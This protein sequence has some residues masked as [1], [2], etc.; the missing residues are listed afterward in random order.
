MMSVLRSSLRLTL[1]IL[2]L[3]GG[4]ALAQDI[5]RLEG[6]GDWRAYSFQEKGSPVCYMVSE[7][8]KDEGKYS[9]RGDIYLM[10]THRP[11][12]K[13]IDVVNVVAGYDY[14]SDSQVQVKVDSNVFDLFTHKDTAWA[15]TED[16]DKRLVEAMIRGK[17]MVVQG[18]SSRGTDTKDTYSLIGFTRAYKSINKACG[19]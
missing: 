4:G 15:A 10:V 8:K 19:R 9:K 16:E 7:P 5:K 13:S 12:E 11:S 2:L 6:A 18:T 14:R 1:P 3:M 17:T